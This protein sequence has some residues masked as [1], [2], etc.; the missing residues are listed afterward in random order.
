MDT[1]FRIIGSR[2]H[3]DLIVAIKSFSVVFSDM[4]M[5]AWGPGLDNPSREPSLGQ[6]KGRWSSAGGVTSTGSYSQQLLGVWWVGSGMGSG[7]DLCKLMSGISIGIK[8]AQS[9]QPAGAA[10]RVLLKALDR[11][12]ERWPGQVAFLGIHFLRKY[13]QNRFPESR[14]KMWG[15]DLRSCSGFIRLC[16]SLILLLDSETTNPHPGVLK[17]S[18]RAVLSRSKRIRKP[19]KNV[20]FRWVCIHC[21]Q[22]S[23]CHHLD[24]VWH[25]PPQL[26]QLYFSL[27]SRYTMC[28]FT[29]FSKICLQSGD[30][31]EKKADVYR[32]AL[33][34]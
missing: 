27:F 24:K 2:S 1:T 21:K 18:R 23:R 29:A 12:P 33:V 28:D 4:W 34:L 13:N 10:S 15:P 20:L 22:S 26:M 8:P 32:F 3:P 25:S 17:S 14:F 11:G 5:G 7:G 9:S 31:E 16:M 30:L 19:S 6:P